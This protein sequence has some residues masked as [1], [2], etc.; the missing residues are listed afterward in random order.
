MKSGR[1]E[2]ATTLVVRRATAPK[3]MVEK[4]M[5]MVLFGLE[6]WIVGWIGWKVGLVE[7]WVGGRLGWCCCDLDCACVVGWFWS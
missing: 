3:M 6:G 7:G 5:L 2:V 1:E 4:R